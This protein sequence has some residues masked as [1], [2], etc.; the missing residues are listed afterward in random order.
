VKK[1]EKRY[2]ALTLY[3][4]I[5]HAPVLGGWRAWGT[6]APEGHGAA[7][8]DRVLDTEAEAKQF[9]VEACEKLDG[10]R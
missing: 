10:D 6:V 2:I 9:I 5:I 8:F 4:H 3:C 7:L 1:T